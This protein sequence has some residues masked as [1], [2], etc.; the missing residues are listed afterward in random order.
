MHAQQSNSSKTG[1]GV[2]HVWCLVVCLSPLLVNPA[3]RHL[4]H[5]FCALLAAVVITMVFA[6]VMAVLLFGLL[7]RFKLLRVEQET[8]LA[9]IDNIIHNG[10]AYPEFVSMAY[11][12]QMGG[13]L[14]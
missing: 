9:G 8:E 5:L 11:R 2:L 13:S 4:W 10:P 7:R 3:V 14:H 6:G 1:G 12:H